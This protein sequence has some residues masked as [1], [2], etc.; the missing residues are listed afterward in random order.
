M[1]R[2]KAESSQ[3]NLPHCI[4]TIMA[5]DLSTFTSKVVVSRKTVLDRNMVTTGH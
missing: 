4:I 1:V 2:S 5:C 3:L